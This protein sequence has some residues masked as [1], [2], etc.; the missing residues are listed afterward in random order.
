LAQARKQGLTQILTTMKNN[1]GMHSAGRSDKQEA[2]GVD[3]CELSVTTPEGAVSVI[4]VPMQSTVT[5][6]KQKLA[7]LNLLAAPAECIHL[8]L[9]HEALRDRSTLQEA[10]VQHSVALV[11][12]TKRSIEGIQRDLKD[13]LFGKG[14][15]KVECMLKEA[16]FLGMQLTDFEEIANSTN[17]WGNET[18]AHRAARNGQEHILRLL[19]E[20]RADLDRTSTNRLAPVHVAASAGKLDALRAL[21]ELRA[22]IL[23]SDQWHST[24]VHLAAQHGHTDVIRYL[25]AAKADLNAS[26]ASG[27]T[28]LRIARNQRRHGCAVAL[29]LEG[30]VDI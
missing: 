21:V 10:G 13:A 7:E 12:L 16:S 3:V 18:P 8:V 29:E 28:P 25:A 11:P 23:P 30:A 19:A 14:D 1:G 26:N 6:L 9:H 22:N 5:D 27:L 15:E 24:P 4:K 2:S 17:N 20:M